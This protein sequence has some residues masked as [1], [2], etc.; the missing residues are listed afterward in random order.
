MLLS[1]PPKKPWYDSAHS[2][3]SPHWI[4][5]YLFCLVGCRNRDSVFR[6]GCYEWFGCFRE[7]WKGQIW[8]IAELCWDGTCRWVSQS[9]SLWFPSKPSNIYLSTLFCKAGVESVR[10][11]LFC[12][13]YS[14]THQ[15]WWL[16]FLKKK[17]V[18]QRILGLL[19]GNVALSRCSTESPRGIG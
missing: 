19:F 18:K 15:F 2:P 16:W 4:N 11:S 5:V 9:S 10:H 8:Y 6:F 12:L 3:V 13:Y 1:K 14:W 17:K 7:S